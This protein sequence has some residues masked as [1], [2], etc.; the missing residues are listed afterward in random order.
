MSTNVLYKPILKLVSV[1]IL[2]L[3]VTTPAASAERPDFKFLRFPTWNLAYQAAAPNGAII[4]EYTPFGQSVHDW[5]QMFTW[6]YFPEWPAH[7]TPRSIMGELKD[8]RM[9]RNPD[10]EWKI[11]TQTYDS[12]VY[13]W[14]VSDEP[15]V[16]AY[17]EIARIVQGADGIH[18][19]RYATKSAS[20]SLHDRRE[21]ARTLK[22]I[23]SVSS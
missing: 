8:L 18:M 16:G 13:E 2:S 17:Y 3:V 21:W 7:A 12:I 20:V 4:E 19:F 6:Q 23:D 22:N 14:K 5:R 15:G 1:L 9:S 11:I 10:T